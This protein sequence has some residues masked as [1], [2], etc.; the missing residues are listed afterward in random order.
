MSAADIV[1]ARLVRAVAF[2]LVLATI[3]GC[4][5]EQ[6]ARERLERRDWDSARQQNSAESF[7]TFLTA[8]PNGLHADEARATLAALK[9]KEARTT[10]TQAAFR[11]FVR[12]HPGL[13]FA[14]EAAARGQDFAVKAV[15]VGEVGTVR[16]NKKATGPIVEITPQW[17][18]RLVTL[19]RESVFA[20]GKDGKKVELECFVPADPDAY[21][22]SVRP[23]PDQ[24]DKDGKYRSTTVVPGLNSFTKS[25]VYVFC[26][27]EG[28]RVFF[29]LGLKDAKAPV[30][31]GLVF[32]ADIESLERF[33]VLGTTMRAA[34][35]HVAT[36]G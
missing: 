1:M 6:Q 16:Q 4:E 20:T 7:G 8:F 3:S 23:Y 21:G 17:G 36:P 13:P 10:N 14:G 22:L 11:D 27:T 24:V 18:A 19:N 12:E 31:L 5:S 35:Q 9:W 25:N 15:G 28:G 29:E 32:E 26:S 34:A 33:H 2:L 30:R